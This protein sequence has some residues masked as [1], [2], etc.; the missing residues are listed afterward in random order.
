[1]SSV[2][3]WH[4][5]TACEQGTSQHFSQHSTGHML[6]AAMPALRRS[7]SVVVIS[8]HYTTVQPDHLRTRDSSVM[9]ILREIYNYLLFFFGLSAVGARRAGTVLDCLFLCSP[10]MSI[11]VPACSC[12]FSI[13]SLITYIICSD[14]H[15][16]QLRRAVIKAG[17]GRGPGKAQH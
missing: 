6:T 13:F 8:Y 4:S 11:R 7:G 10:A 14:M 15:L 17:C 9:N 5:L 2:S 12:S 16:E 1:M 3:C